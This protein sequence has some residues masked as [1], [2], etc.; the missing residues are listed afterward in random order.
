MC[1]IVMRYRLEIACHKAIYS[2][3]CSRDAKQRNRIGHVLKRLC[4]VIQKFFRSET[5]RDE[6]F[7]G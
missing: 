6:I 1:G 7:G 2:Q 5:Q 3:L 4:K